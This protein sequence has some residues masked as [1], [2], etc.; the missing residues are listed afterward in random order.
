MII[1]K[2]LKNKYFIV[3]VVL[4]SWLLYFDKNDVF[5]QY[6]LVQKCNKLNAE[7]DYYIAE[8]EKNKLEINELQNNSKS[9]ETFARE[10]Y[11]M[12][13]DDEDVFVF[14]TK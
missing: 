10:K 13:K 14:T 6:E 7:R 8:I 1:F 3:I 5:T 2:I 12:K 9:L 11:L 4:I